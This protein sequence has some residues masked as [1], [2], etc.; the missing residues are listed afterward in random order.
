MESCRRRGHRQPCL[1]KRP[2]RKLPAR[3]A[4]SPAGIATAEPAPLGTAEPAA[5][6]RRLRTSFVHIHGAA[7]K[8]SAIQSV[9]GVLSG[10]G[11]AHLDES[12]AARLTGFTVRHNVDAVNGAVLLKRGLDIG[13]SGLIAQISD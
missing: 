13:G 3:V 2:E 11:I 1:A 4:A 8:L 9:N 6:A 7:A 5:A 12:E 10:G